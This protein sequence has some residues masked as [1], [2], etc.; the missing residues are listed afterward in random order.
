[1]TGDLAGRVIIQ[2]PLPVGGALPGWGLKIW[3]ADTGQQVFSASEITATVNGTA[4]GIVVA[5][6]VLFAD[7][8]GNPLYG[9]QGQTQIFLDDDKNVLT[10]TFR[11]QV[12][13]M[14]VPPVLSQFPVRPRRPRR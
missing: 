4:D 3:D 10:G 9:S 1:V 13:E 12:A 8:D 11:F 7:P 2:W 5:D 6:L 14:R